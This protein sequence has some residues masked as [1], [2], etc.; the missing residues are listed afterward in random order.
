MTPEFI[1][2]FI[3]GEGSFT[4]TCAVNDEAKFGV[5]PSMQFKMNVKEKTILEEIQEF[6]GIGRVTKEADKDSQWA[7]RITKTS[8]LHELAN[9]IEQHTDCGFEDSKKYKSFT[10]WHELLNERKELLNSKGGIRRFIRQSREIND[11]SARTTGRSVEE[12]EAIVDSSTNYICGAES[13]YSNCCE[14]PVDSE[15]ET[16]YR[17]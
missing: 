9:W 8:E 13:E 17:H 6:V 15:N 11:D 3:A 2:G 1:L 14:N 7:W 16:C 10:I 5:Y 12:L 4:T